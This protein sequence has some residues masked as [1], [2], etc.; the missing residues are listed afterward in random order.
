MIYILNSCNKIEMNVIKINK[1]KHEIAN[2][3]VFKKKGK[4]DNTSFFMFLLETVTDEIT[5]NTLIFFYR[6]NR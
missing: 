1:K 4:R 6:A 3:H 2:A 5:N